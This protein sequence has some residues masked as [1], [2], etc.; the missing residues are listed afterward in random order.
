M[1]DIMQGVCV[2]ILVKKPSITN[3]AV[4][5]IDLYGKRKL[6]LKALS[7]LTIPK[8]TLKE[9]QQIKDFESINNE[10]KQILEGILKKVKD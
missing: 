7:E 4:Y 9:N 5:Q 10:Q 3:K 8:N 6:K 2:I 1:F